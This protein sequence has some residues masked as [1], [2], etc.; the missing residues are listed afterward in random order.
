M[1]YA[2][3]LTGLKV[4][5]PSAN[6]RIEPYTLYQF[7]ESKSGDAISASDNQIKVGGNVKWAIDP[8]AVLDLT[9]N[10]DFAQA[11]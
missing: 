6:I 11:D 8:N 3:K 2:A 4:P 7:D 9:I 5:P 10:T 1:T